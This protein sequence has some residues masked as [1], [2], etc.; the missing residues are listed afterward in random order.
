MHPHLKRQLEALGLQAGLPPDAATWQQLLSQVGDTYAEWEQLR[1][2]LGRQRAEL[3]ALHDTMVGLLNGRDTTSLLEASLS[4]AA[5]LVGTPH[6]YLGLVTPDGSA[7]EVRIGL[8]YFA[9]SIGYRLARGQGM[10]GRVWAR[11][12]PMVVADY[13]NWDGRRPG[14]DPVHALVGLPL[15]SG[16]DI[17]GVIGL[18][19]LERDLTFTAEEIERL[20]GFAQLASLAIENAGVYSA[21]REELNERQRAEG[22][23]RELLAHL[24]ER[25]RQLIQ[26]LVAGNSLHLN[27]DLDSVLQEIVTAAHEALGF[28]AVVLRL[29]DDDGWHFRVRAIAGLDKAAGQALASR[30]YPWEVFA[31]LM[32]EPFRRGGCYLIPQGAFDWEQ[33]FPGPTYNVLGPPSLETAADANAWQPDDYLFVPIDLRQGQVGGIIAV[34]APLD[35]RRPSDE[36]LRALEIFA[37]QAGVAIEN[38]RLY[39]RLHQELAERRRTAETLAAARDAAEAANRAKS[40]FLANMNHELRTPLNAI[41]GYSELAHD[42]AEASGYTDIA[43]DLA[44]VRTA[45]NHLFALIN[46]ILDLSKIEAG[47]MDLLP[48]LFDIAGLVAQVA[49]TLRPAI[50]KNGNTLLIDHPP[51]L[52]LMRADPTRVRQVLIN[53]LGNAAKFTNHGRITLSVTRDTPGAWVRFTVADTGIGMTPEQV[54]TIFKPFTQADPSTTRRYGGTGLGL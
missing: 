39:N 48:E 18:A 11:G 25:N 38:A 4:H 15:R 53:L 20:A 7:L 44:K 29:V 36:T 22:S 27:L 5:A 21:V 10:A 40:T 43:A 49:T 3:A 47:K 1:T 31:R 51:N 46:G 23:V 42:Q 54:A 8:G 13:Q 24:E 41:L 17:V 45:G 6:G 34:D 50:D 32:Q 16:P 30:V 52:G 35:G 12:E 37:N 26:I 19:H 33:D 28:K 2:A 14:C 9:N